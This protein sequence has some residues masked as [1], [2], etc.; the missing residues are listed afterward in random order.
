MLSALDGE[1][2]RAGNGR[3]GN[4]R[5]DNGWTPTTAPDDP[6][7]PKRSSGTGA[8]ALHGVAGGSGT[9][10][11]VNSAMIPQVELSS[12]RPK[13]SL[14]IVSDALLS[15]ICGAGAGGGRT[16]D[17]VTVTTRVSCSRGIVL[18]ALAAPSME[19]RARA[20]RSQEM[21]LAALLNKVN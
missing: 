10:S 17:S 6:K 9:H 11:G 8:A 14:G 3:A 13:H 18:A 2:K 12:G 21:V 16:A 7:L 15:K 4:G 20:R 1:A 5:A 19:S